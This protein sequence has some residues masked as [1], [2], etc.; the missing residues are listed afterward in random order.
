MMTKASWSLVMMG[1]CS[2]A[3]VYQVVSPLGDLLRQ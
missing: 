3:G 1:A 2:Y